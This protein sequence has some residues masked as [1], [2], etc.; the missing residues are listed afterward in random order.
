MEEE[1]K[2]GFGDIL[3]RVIVVVLG[4]L[5]LIMLGLIVSTVFRNA[6]EREAEAPARGGLEGAAPPLESGQASDA[7]F[8]T[9]PPGAFAEFGDL[10]I[11]APAGSDIVSAE[12]VND[13]LL[14]RVEG[15]DQDQVVVV[16]L[17]G[18]RNIGRVIVSN[19]E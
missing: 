17:R 18:G 6:D 11:E 8:P 4:I 13:L 2:L 5:I 16:D 12:I 9:A 19:E 14:V 7:I 15:P 1:V 3:I 10:E